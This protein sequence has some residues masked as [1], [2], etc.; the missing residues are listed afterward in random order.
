[1]FGQQHVM[2]SSWN[3]AVFMK[4]KLTRTKRANGKKEMNTNGSVALQHTILGND[5]K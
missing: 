3:V 2:V 1:M 5:Q 4:I